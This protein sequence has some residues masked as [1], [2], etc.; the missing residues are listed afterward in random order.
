MIAT[1]PRTKRGPSRLPSADTLTAG[2]RDRFGRLFRPAVA[3][4]LLAVAAFGYSLVALTLALAHARAQPEPY[5]RIDAETY[6][7]WGALF[8]APVILAAWLLA[9]DAVFL[10][11]LPARPR[12]QFLPVLTAM[13][14]AVGVGTLGTLLQDFVTSPL[15]ALGVIDEQA[16]EQSITAHTGWFIFIWCFLVAYVVLFVV[17][18]PV[19]VKRST[20]IGGWRAVGIG[21]AAFGVFQVVEY[22]FIR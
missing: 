7:Q 15:R 6:F 8:Y 19:A 18:F 10:L 4:S 20:G 3:Y 12:L 13:A 16:W 21:L 11:A 1:P 9:S 14:A 5:V 17:A 2:T 22:V